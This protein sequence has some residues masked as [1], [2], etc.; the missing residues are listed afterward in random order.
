MTFTLQLRCYVLSLV[1]SALT[2]G[3]TVMP[4]SVFISSVPGIRYS[5]CSDRVPTRGIRE[6]WMGGIGLCVAEVS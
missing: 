1:A 4:K 6:G 3:S 5:I 2:S